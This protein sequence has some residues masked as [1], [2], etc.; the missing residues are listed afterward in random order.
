M[1]GHIIRRV[2]LLALCLGSGCN[3]SGSDTAVYVTESGD[4]AWP[5]GQVSNATVLTRDAS[6]EAPLSPEWGI[7]IDND[8][9]YQL[10][11][12]RL[13]QLLDPVDFATQVV[14]ASWVYSE[15]T[16][17]IELREWEALNVDGR[18]QL[19]ATFSDPTGGCDD[20]CDEEGGALIAIAMPKGNGPASVCR[21]VEN[22]CL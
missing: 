11:K 22:G 1:K 2:G 12:G 17:G 16:C 6:Y 15:C 19:S 9:D 10:F 4:C 20:C 3:N 21:V 5:N 13:G 14:L 18:S 8:A 7:V